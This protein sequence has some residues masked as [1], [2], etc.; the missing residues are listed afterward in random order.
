MGATP[1][2]FAIV[3]ANEASWAD[4]QAIF[5]TTS[6]PGHCYCQWFKLRNRDWASTPV[7]ERRAGLRE[8]THCG[9][10]D[11]ERTT[12]MVAYLGTEPVG[13]VAAEPRPAYQRL[14]SA[15]YIWDGREEDKA[16]DSVWAVTCFVTRRGY[17]RRGISYALAAATVGFAR[18][19]GAQ[20]LEAY[21]ILVAPGERVSA[22]ALYV[23]TSSMFAAAGLAEV[24]RIGSRRVLMR[25]DFS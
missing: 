24:S 2:E 10:P 16:D 23:G 1:A 18:Q 8:Q 21:P 5:G 20:A 14:A 19:R 15:R 13:W 6:D 7:T 11:A 12:G 9:N 17:R 3:P 25:V 22:A 4:L